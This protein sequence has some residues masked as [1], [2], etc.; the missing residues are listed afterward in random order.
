[1]AFVPFFEQNVEFTRRCSLRERLSVTL[2]GSLRCVS[3]RYFVQ[4]V[5]DVDR[6]GHWPDLGLSVFSLSFMFDAF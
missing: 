3:L 5:F 1:M 4:F 6:C 2:V